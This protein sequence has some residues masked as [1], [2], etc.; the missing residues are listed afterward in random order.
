MNKSTLFLLSIFSTINFSCCAMEMVTNTVRYNANQAVKWVSENTFSWI[1]YARGPEAQE[2]KRDYKQSLKAFNANAERLKQ[3]PTDMTYRWYMADNLVPIKR[4][5]SFIA[6]NIKKDHPNYLGS[7]REK[8]IDTATKMLASTDV[9]LSIEDITQLQSTINKFANF[10]IKA[11]NHVNYSDS[12][13]MC[14]ENQSINTSNLFL[15]KSDIDLLN[16]PELSELFQKKVQEAEKID[17]F[18]QKMQAFNQ[19]Q[20]QQQNINGQKEIEQ[21]IIK[22]DDEKQQDQQKEVIEFVQIEKTKLEEHTNN[23]IAL[24]QQVASFK[25]TQ[26]TW[27]KNNTEL[28]NK[29][30]TEEKKVKD[31][32]ELTNSLQTDN[33]KLIGSNQ[34][35]EQLN[36]QLLEQKKQLE[37]RITSLTSEIT[38]Y[39]RIGIGVAGIAAFLFYYFEL[40]TKCVEL[41]SQLNHA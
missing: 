10:S 13:I 27:E 4:E 30:T 24:E 34:E 33:W 25:N 1:D 37:A 2:F 9:Q 36:Q 28:T 32:T 20:E 11:N 26:E 39:K 8:Y 15:E 6:Y 31:L 22:N 16:D 21:E 12:A 40:H 19:K 23:I 5:I 29:L 3:K 35:K 14:G 18:Y 7:L 17:N 38:L 41:L